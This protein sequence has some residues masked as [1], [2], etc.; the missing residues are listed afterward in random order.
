MRKVT[1]IVILLLLLFTYL[2]FSNSD[3]VVVKKDATIEGFVNNLRAIV[4]RGTFWEHQLLLT[5]KKY[6]DNLV[7]KESLFSKSREIDQQSR[8]TQKNVNE[9]IREFVSPEQYAAI[10]LR[11]KADS[12]EKVGV[13]RE[14]DEFTEKKRIETI[15]E[16]KIVIQ[17]I[18]TKLNMSSR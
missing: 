17:I 8:E 6:A 2:Y 11:D 10:L 18:K 12:I 1:I 5:K 16:C 13:Y 4:Q 9:S 7:P 15:E 3:E 14:I